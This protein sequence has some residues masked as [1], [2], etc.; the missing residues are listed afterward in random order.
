MNIKAYHG[1]NQNITGQFKHGLDDKGVTSKY[2]YWFTDSIDE[3]K[4]YGK[5]SSNRMRSNAEDHDK[6]IEQY[7]K[8]IDLAERKGNWDLYD[9]LI[10]E[11]EAIEFG[12]YDKSYYVYTVSLSLENPFVYEVGDEYFDQE[13]VIKHAIK[14]K[15]DSVIFKNISD[16]PYGGIGRTTQYVVFDPSDIKIVS[17]H[18][19]DSDS[20]TESFVGFVKSLDRG[21]NKSLIEA[22]VDGYTVIFESTI[23]TITLYRGMAQQFDPTY[24]LSKT[25]APS[26]YSTWTDNP[27]LARQYAGSD[28]YVYKIKLPANEMGVEYLDKDG[29]RV[30]F[31][32]NEKKAGLHG[33]KGNEYLVYTDHELYDP[34]SITLIDNIMESV[35]PN[36]KYIDISDDMY[37]MDEDIDDLLNQV[38]PLVSR[39]GINVLRGKDLKSIAVIGDTVVGALFTEF[40]DGEFS[41]DVV[42]N[43]DN[44][45]SGIGKALTNNAMSEYDMY[46]DMDDVKLVIDAV[47]PRYAEYLQKQYGLSVESE[48]QG[49]IILTDKPEISLNESVQDMDGVTSNSNMVFLHGGN[50]DDIQSIDDFNKWT[51]GR[52]EYGPGLYLTTHYGTATKYAKGSRKLYKIE[53]EKG[54]DINSVSLDYDTVLQFISTILSKPKQKEYI[55]HASRFVKDGKINASIFVNIFINYDLIS[56]KNGSAIRKFLVDNGIDYEVVQNA[57]GWGETMLVLYNMR[58]IKNVQ[59]VSPQ[60]KSILDLPSINESIDN[61]DSPELEKAIHL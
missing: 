54:T 12:D 19:V 4:Q 27:E 56:S 41:F 2:G 14:K 7:I 20:I 48:Y 8:R 45:S 17:K 44:Q 26:G 32:N 21:W 24:D 10:E 31:F 39:S 3:A 49:H 22:I 53:V 34:N 50:L 42:V 15:H 43:N 33:V 37:E 58:K 1:T 16:S 29:D 30:L 9:K 5:Q 59:R 55:V 40:N 35:N 47:N 61:I 57:F 25:D 23:P 11:M 36:I 46:S 13:T 51:K 6:L 28:G 18:K 52:V 38:D 60:D